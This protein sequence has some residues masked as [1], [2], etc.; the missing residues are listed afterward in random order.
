ML[1]ILIDILKVLAD[2]R[3]QGRRA[4][5]ASTH[6]AEQLPA[7]GTAGSAEATMTK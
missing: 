4:R 5:E 2:I 6:Q 1:V 3:S 7:K